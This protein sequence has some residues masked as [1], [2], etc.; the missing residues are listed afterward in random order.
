MTL[1]LCFWIL[2]LLWLVANG[3]AFYRQGVFPGEN[4][5]PFLL[6]GLLGWAVFGAPIHG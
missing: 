4:I 3:A 1:S 5:L 6:F 2:M